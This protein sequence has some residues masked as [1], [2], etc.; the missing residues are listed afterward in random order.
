M[1]AAGHGRLNAVGCLWRSLLFGNSCSYDHARKVNNNGETVL[2]ALEGAIDHYANAGWSAKLQ[3]ECHEHIPDEDLDE[4]DHV[5]ALLLSGPDDLV[6][7]ELEEGRFLVGLGAQ[8]QLCV[9]VGQEDWVRAQIESV[10]YRCTDLVRVP[11]R[12]GD[13][14]EMWARVWLFQ[15]ATQNP[16]AMAGHG[17]GD[18]GDESDSGSDDGV[19]YDSEAED[20]FHQQ[21]QQQNN[22]HQQHNNQQHQQHNNQQQH[23]NQH[24]HQQHHQSARDRQVSDSADVAV[25]A[26]ESAVSAGSDSSLWCHVLPRRWLH[27]D[28]SRAQARRW[29]PT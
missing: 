9:E 2:E 8:H 25:Y 23:H 7:N 14:H 26:T 11:W 6:N 16:A 20:Q 1:A 10:G 27:A 29:H 3:I 22:Q 19:G 24:Q 28:R 15:E 17:H 21:Q 5:F 12:N 13:D 18:G 4:D